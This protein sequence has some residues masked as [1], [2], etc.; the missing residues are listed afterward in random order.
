MKKGSN[1]GDNQPSYEPLILR[2]VMRCGPPFHC[3]GSR[4]R[5][6]KMKR[7]KRMKTMKSMNKLAYR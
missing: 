7:R 1:R 4:R 5:K 3:S 2:T 6:N